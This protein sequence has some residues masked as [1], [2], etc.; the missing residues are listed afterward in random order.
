M[1]VPERLSVSD[2]QQIVHLNNLQRVVL[3]VVAG[4]LLLTG[5]GLLMVA[6]LPERAAYTGEYITGI[7]YVAP[8]MGAIAP[9]FERTSLTGETLSL[10]GLRGEVVILNFWATWCAPCVTEM[11]ELQ[12]IYDE[13][14]DSGLHILGIN[15]GESPAVIREWVREQDLTFDIIPDTTGDLTRLYRLRGQPTTAVIAPSGKI[16]AIFYGPVRAG[17]LRDLLS[18]WL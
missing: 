11:P 16:A 5:G 17:T 18:D 3:I 2:H 12:M 15:M 6:G 7:G 4:L 1:T 10:D 13:F 14:Q 8:E 9:P